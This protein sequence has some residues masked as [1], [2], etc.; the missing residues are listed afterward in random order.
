MQAEIRGEI[1]IPLGNNVLTLSARADRIEQFDDGSCAILDYKTGLPPTE[2]QVRTGLSPQLTL[3]AAILRRG[4]FK[5]IAAGASVRELVYVALRGGDPPGEGEALPFKEGTPDT[6]ADRALVKLTGI[7]ARFFD[8]A[9]P[10]LSLVHLMWKTHYGDYDH[11]ARVKEWS[12]T[13]GADNSA[14][15][16]GGE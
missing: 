2:K 13:G 10:Y 3:E 1:T 15:D 7:A 8:E 11:L 5:G 14:G 16:G 4:G 6:Q 9:T 12:L